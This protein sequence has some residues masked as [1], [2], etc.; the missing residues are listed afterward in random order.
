MFCAPLKR[1]HWE[2]VEMK[3]ANLKMIENLE[4]M[5]FQNFATVY[6]NLSTPA[7]YEEAIRRREGSISHRGPFVVRTGHQQL[8]HL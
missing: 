1:R 7:L 2:V 5:G 6:R 8:V 4:Q 3:K